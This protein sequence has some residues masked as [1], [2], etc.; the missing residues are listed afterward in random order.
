MSGSRISSAGL[1]VR[2]RA[3][4]RASHHGM[5]E[6]DLIMGRFADDEIGSLS[7]IELARNS[8]PCSTCRTRRPFPG[9]PAR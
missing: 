9:S 4:F 1:D 5:R 7:E 2:A 6:M 8:R 3:L